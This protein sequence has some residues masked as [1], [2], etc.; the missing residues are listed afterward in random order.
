MKNSVA[1]AHA[2]KSWTQ[3]DLADAV[4]A[5]T[6]CIKAVELGLYDPSLIFAYDIAEALGT[7]IVEASRQSSEDRPKTT[8]LLSALVFRSL[9]EILMTHWKRTSAIAS[10]LAVQLGRHVREALS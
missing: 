9:E 7:T 1:E 4:N 10:I 6:A 2:R 8:R 3:V 5:G